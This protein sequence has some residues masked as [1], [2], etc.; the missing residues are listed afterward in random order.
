MNPDLDTLVVALYVTIGDLG[1]RPVK[2]WAFELSL[3]VSCRR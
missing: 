1:G 2:W 3:G